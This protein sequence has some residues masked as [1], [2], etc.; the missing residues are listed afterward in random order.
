M[1]Q[2]VKP[3]RLI[4][5]NERQNRPVYRVDAHAY[6]VLQTGLF[7]ESSE[8]SGIVNGQNTIIDHLCALGRGHR[9]YTGTCNVLL[10]ET[11]EI[12]IS[13]D[14]AVHKDEILGQ[15][16][17]Q[18]QRSDR[19]QWGHFKGVVDSNAPLLPLLKKGLNDVR[20]MVNRHTDMVE[21]STRKLPHNDFQYWIFTYG[22]Q[23][24]RED[25]GVG[26]QSRSLAAG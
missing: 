24:L 13:Q 2:V 5:W 8:Q 16:L 6:K 14:V 19:T 18:P 23:G 10:E 17:N 20:L 4:R 1:H 21:P 12:Q 22:H 9:E 7:T 3:I 11:I 26:P 25:Y 15:V